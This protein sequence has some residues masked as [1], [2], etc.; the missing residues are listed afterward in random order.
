MKSL[1]LGWLLALLAGV[2]CPAIARAHVL[3]EYL[4]A[5]L[6][7][8]EPGDI[9][10]KMNLTPGVE[11][12][13]KVLALLDEDRDGEV[14]SDEGIAYAGRLKRDLTA[15]LDGRDVDLRLT[16]SRVPPLAD[17]RTGHGIAQ[18]EFSLDSGTLTGGLHKLVVQNRHTPDLGVYLFNAARPTSDAIRIVRQNRNQNQSRGEIEFA[19]SPPGDIFPRQ[20]FEATALVAWCVGLFT[21]AACL[22]GMWTWRKRPKSA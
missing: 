10:L 2:A 13:D 22:A 3:D 9:R 15:R 1:A 19:Y 5:T 21:V 12:A 4:Q 7:C 16:A 18:I 6:V 14:S 20:S 11:I 8:I 17:L